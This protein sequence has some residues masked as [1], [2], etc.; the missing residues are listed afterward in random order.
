MCCLSWYKTLRTQ[1]F[2]GETLE[3]VL[4]CVLGRAESAVSA[5]LLRLS[6]PFFIALPSPPP[7]AVR[8]VC[9]STCE[10]RPG[11]TWWM[12]GGGRLGSDRKLTQPR[13][14]VL[15]KLEQR[16]DLLS[17]CKKKQN[18]T[19]KN[20][21]FSSPQQKETSSFCAVC[22]LLRNHTDSG[23]YLRFLCVCSAQTKQV[24]MVVFFLT[25]SVCKLSPVPPCTVRCVCDHLLGLE[26]YIIYRTIHNVQQQE[27]FSVKQQNK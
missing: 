8:P 10:R 12:R 1:Q 14:F 15:R 13:Q 24:L 18:K 4:G 6:P 3:W 21:L 16:V 17:W 25:A 26:L 5:F 11:P 2:P 23:D 9:L 7:P 19:K 20:Y 22:I 27:A